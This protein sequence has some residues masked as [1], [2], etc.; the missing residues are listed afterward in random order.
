M[1]KDA[2]HPLTELISI[3]AKAGIGMLPGGGLLTASYE[4]LNRPGFVRHLANSS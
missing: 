2:E 1:T 3:A 4:G